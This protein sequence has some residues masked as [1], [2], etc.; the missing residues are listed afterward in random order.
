MS[1]RSFTVLIY[2]CF[3]LSPVNFLSNQFNVDTNSSCMKSMI[4]LTLTWRAICPAA[5]QGRWKRATWVTHSE[6]KHSLGPYSGVSLCHK[7]LLKVPS[8][9]QGPRKGQQASCGREQASRYSWEPH[10]GLYYF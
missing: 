10:G 4:L 8:S 3:T 5:S 2:N 7:P 9:T 1:S 6:T